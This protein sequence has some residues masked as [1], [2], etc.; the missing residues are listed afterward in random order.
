MEIEPKALSPATV[1]RELSEILG[2]GLLMLSPVETE[3][4]PPF[5]K[6]LRSVKIAGSAITGVNVSRF[7]S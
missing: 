6:A 3:R 1:D 5:L 4:S 7:E 2:E